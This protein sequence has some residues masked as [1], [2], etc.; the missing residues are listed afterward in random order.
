MSEK[1]KSSVTNAT[2]AQQRERPVKMRKEIWTEL[3]GSPHTGDS[4]AR[5]GF[6]SR[7][8]RKLGY[9]LM[10]F[11]EGDD[12]TVPKVDLVIPQGSASECIKSYEQHQDYVPAIVDGTMI[13]EEGKEYHGFLSFEPDLA[14]SEGFLACH[15]L[16]QDMLAKAKN[17]LSEDILNKPR[18]HIMV[19]VAQPEDTEMKVA[20]EQLRSL[21]KNGG[22]TLFVTTSPRTEAKKLDRYRRIF[23]AIAADTG[24]SDCAVE[25]ID[26][27]R[28]KDEGNPYLLL[29]S[30]ADAHVI[31][32]ESYSMAS[33]AMM[34][35]KPIY[36]AS[37]LFEDEMGR[38][39]DWLPAK[40][41]ERFRELGVDETLP[42]TLWSSIN[43]TEHF[44]EAALKEYEAF[45]GQHKDKHPL[46]PFA[47]NAEKIMESRA[48]ARDAAHPLK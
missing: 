45:I 9:K 21:A 31:I 33:E 34:T 42:D 11:V 39:G 7:L 38:I 6:A 40:D 22:G 46:N 20:L 37:D 25:F 5:L 12:W 15:N 29:L 47:T 3:T 13:V 4:K 27:Q 36:Y 30:D 32:G 17:T 8:A 41:R 48:S 14:P 35:G 16:S 19:C 23:D 10:C 1:P 18:P 24:R 28:V 26:F 44:V 2:H 43:T